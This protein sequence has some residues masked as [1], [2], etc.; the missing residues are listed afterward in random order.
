[1][2]KRK[3]TEKKL[4]KAA[5]KWAKTHSELTEMQ[6]HIFVKNTRYIIHIQQCN[7]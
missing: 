1:M 6:T 4:L 5:K 7:N 2:K 3:K